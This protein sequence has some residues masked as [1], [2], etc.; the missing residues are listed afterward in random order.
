MA[1]ELERLELREAIEDA[2]TAAFVESQ[3]RLLAA[4]N[5]TWDESAANDTARRVVLDQA[6]ADLRREID[7]ATQRPRGVLAAERVRVELARLVWRERRQPAEAE[8]IYAASI[9]RLTSVTVT[10]AQS[11]DR[12]RLLQAAFHGRFHTVMESRGGFELSTCLTAWAEHLEAALERYRGAPWVGHAW[13]RFAIAQGLLAESR[14]TAGDDEAQR[15]YRAA[16]A[17]P[18]VSIRHGDSQRRLPPH[19]IHRA[20]WSASWLPTPS[21]ESEPT[22]DASTRGPAGGHPTTV[23]AERLFF[24]DWLEDRCEAFARLARA[25]FLA[26]DFEAAVGLQRETVA[27]RSELRTRAATRRRRWLHLRESFTLG[28]FLKAAGELSSSRL[29]LEATLKDA[30]SLV[31]ECPEWPAPRALCRETRDSLAIAYQAGGEESRALDLLLSATIALSALRLDREPLAALDDQ[32][33]IREELGKA[34]SAA[35]RKSLAWRNFVESLTLRDAI[36]RREPHDE[37]SLSRLLQAAQITWELAVTP[38]E[39]RESLNAVEP[40][41]DRLDPDRVSVHESKAVQAAL[42]QL[43]LMR[44]SALQTLNGD[45]EA[46]EELVALIRDSFSRARELLANAGKLPPEK[47]R[48]IDGRIRACEAVLKKL[49][50]Q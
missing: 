45:S 15:Q 24:D 1:F 16:V 18:P 37:S 38:A 31:N 49:R 20:T 23:G 8:R 42:G 32:A 36:W 43:H 14:A 34:H 40:L 12:D 5:E 19:S 33:V 17:S 3:H 47:T 41:L 35:G 4:V 10:S 2:R 26:G 50:K 21:A 29:T 13:T 44:G 48:D 28:V 22:V 11:E 7:T 30:L 25:E 6:E 39:W 27:A 9:E 46:R